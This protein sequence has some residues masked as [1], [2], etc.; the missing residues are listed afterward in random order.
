[1]P[2]S[3]FCIPHSAP[4]LIRRS[5]HGQIWAPQNCA[6]PQ[7]EPVHLTVTRGK[8][9]RTGQL[10]RRIC[11][12]ILQLRAGTTKIWSAVAER[13]G[14]TAFRAWSC[15][16]KRRGASLPAALQT[17]WLRRKP[18]W[19]HLCPSVV[20]FCMVTT[21]MIANDQELTVTQERIDQ[22]TFSAFSFSACQRLEWSRSPLVHFSFPRISPVLRSPAEG[23][24]IPR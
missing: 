14:D 10:S 18:R 2:Q 21:Y 17:L 8:A 24:R 7:R 13:S 1:M 12:T 16:R 9:R 6:F 15:F 20:L 23:G 5:N 11:T 19:V 3:A 4:E 22:V